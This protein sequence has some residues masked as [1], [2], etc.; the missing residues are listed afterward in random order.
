[1]LSLPGSVLSASGVFN[2]S[3]GPVGKEAV[4]RTSVFGLGW[5]FVACADFL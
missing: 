2:P 5:V 4:F 1:M 3:N